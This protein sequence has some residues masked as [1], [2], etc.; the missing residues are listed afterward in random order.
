MPTGRAEDPNAHYD[1][2]HKA[3]LYNVN[4]SYI[5]E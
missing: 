5:S 2:D 1:R 4:I 3:I